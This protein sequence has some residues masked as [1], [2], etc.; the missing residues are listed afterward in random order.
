MKTVPLGHSNKVSI[1]NLHWINEFYHEFRAL[2]FEKLKREE[3]LN[4]LQAREAMK[5]ITPRKSFQQS[6][7]Q[8]NVDSQNGDDPSKNDE[9]RLTSFRYLACSSS[10]SSSDDGDIYNAHFLDVSEDIEE[11][12]PD[13]EQEERLKKLE[14][15]LAKEYMKYKKPRRDSGVRIFRLRLLN[16]SRVASDGYLFNLLPLFELHPLNPQ[17]RPNPHEMHQWLLHHYHLP[18]H[19]PQCRHLLSPLNSAVGLCPCPCL[20][21]RLEQTARRKALHIL[22]IR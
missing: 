22:Q 20:K 11:W 21:F 19:Q 17:Q 18:L 16:S 7:T 10:S 12:M 1:Q 3:E 5:A 4:K 15:V 14:V 6:D 2:E 9:K 13:Q 8:F